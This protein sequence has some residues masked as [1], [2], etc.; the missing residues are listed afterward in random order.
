MNRWTISST[1]LLLFL[2]KSFVHGTSVLRT[3]LYSQFLS[4]LKEFGFLDVIE[5]AKRSDGRT[6][7]LSDAGEGVTLTHFVVL[8]CRLLSTSLL[9][10]L[11]ADDVF[12]FALELSRGEIDHVSRID[13]LA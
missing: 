9:H 1:N 12:F 6:V 5:S 11:D 2:H 10:R 8:H 7:F 4:Y 13:R 3:S